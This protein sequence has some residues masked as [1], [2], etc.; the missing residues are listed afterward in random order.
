MVPLKIASNVSRFKPALNLNRVLADLNRGS[1]S[2]NSI[3]DRFYR[4]D[5]MGSYKN[6]RRQ[7]SSQNQMCVFKEI[8]IMVYTC[9]SRLFS[10]KSINNSRDF[11][12]TLSFRNSSVL[13][14]FSLIL[15]LFSQIYILW[16]IFILFWI[17]KF[18]FFFWNLNLQSIL[19]RKTTFKLVLH[20]K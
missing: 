9:K 10:F 14:N 20:C 3:S 18:Y 11:L 15:I 13:I 1:N 8:Q 12:S 6:K 19:I 7:N 2:L 17:Y 4:I 5:M 16:F